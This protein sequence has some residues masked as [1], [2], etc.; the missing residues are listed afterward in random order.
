MIQT[1]QGM[2][3]HIDEHRP[4]NNKGVGNCTKKAV[5][6]NLGLFSPCM[7]LGALKPISYNSA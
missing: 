4:T 6:E 3:K 2:L 1:K 5:K 7:F